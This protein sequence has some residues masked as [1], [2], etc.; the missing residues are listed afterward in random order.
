MTHDHEWFRRFHHLFLMVILLSA[1]PKTQS[2]Q[3]Y[4]QFIIPS[5]IYWVLENIFTKRKIWKNI[6]P[7]MAKLKSCLDVKDNGR[8]VQMKVSILL[9][10]LH[11]IPRSQWRIYKHTRTV[12]HS[13]VWGG[14]N[15]VSQKKI[16]MYFAIFNGIT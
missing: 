7:W 10:S 8:Q 13:S 15:G 5:V 3:V 9:S 1:K 6:E 4:P 2:Y 16:C 12:L 14:W 11:S